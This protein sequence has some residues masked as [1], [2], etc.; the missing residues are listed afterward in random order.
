M[1]NIKYVW[2]LVAVAVITS[3]KK[4]L[5]PKPNVAAFNIINAALSL[6]QVAVDFSANHLPYYQ[7]MSFIPYQSSLEFSL[8]S[9]NTPFNVISS[10]D[11]SAVLL[12]GGFNLV[13]GGIYSF[14]L[15]GNNANP[16]TLF[17]KDNIPYYPTDSLSGARFINLCS[18]SQPLNITLQGGTGNVS[19]N[20][21]YKKITAFQPYS[22][23]G[24]ITNNGGY[25]FNITDG[26]GN[27]LT[28]FNWNPTVY[29]NYT[30]VI[31]GLVS[32]GSIS[33]FAVNNF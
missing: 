17:M 7:Q 10:A 23:V 22:A 14:Y 18:D 29:K 6:P 20:L 28:T 21:A 5:G 15:A 8:P 9:G 24:N 12:H 31:T 19:S 30:L 16:D 33:I 32:D 25:N 26:S 3:C 2:I 4:D 11:T 1:K 13:K 27:V